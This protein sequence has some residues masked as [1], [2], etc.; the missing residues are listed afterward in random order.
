MEGEILLIN[1]G[2]TI[3]EKGLIL[4][5]LE[6][7]M[8]E[9]QLEYQREKLLSLGFEIKEP[10]VYSYQISRGLLCI[11]TKLIEDGFKPTYL[12]MDYEKDQHPEES[13]EKIL[14]PH[15]QNAKIA[16][17][18]SYTFNFDDAVE[19]AKTL[20]LTNPE[21]KVIFGGPHVTWLDIETIENPYID[22]VVRG[23]GENIFRDVCRNLLNG[24]NLS[25]IKG[26]TYKKENGEIVRNSP[27]PFLKGEEIPMPAYAL[28]KSIKNPT[29]VI[30][31]TRG[32]PMR[33]TFCAE[34]AFWKIV[35]HRKINDV[36][37]ELKILRSV[38]GY[39]A[40]H[41]C[42]PYFPINKKYSEEL[43]HQI[44][45]EKI[46]MYFNCNVRVDKLDMDT[47]RLLS[48]SNFYGVF[49]GIESGS[50]RVLREMRKGITYEEY[51]SCLK[52]IRKYIPII[53]T[54]W[55]VGH[56]GENVDTI[57]ESKEKIKLLLKE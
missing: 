20:K 46:E 28:I 19:I 49:I 22:I 24:K 3:L 4:E 34:S 51:Y 48:S 52:K 43:L 7:R 54:S 38:L 5:P 57:K 2:S 44:K 1:P 40:I 8:T 18:T 50:N 9:I 30:E 16:R 29:I 14:R 42:D 11:A 53:D 41:I 25:E 45:T 17:I 10:P 13:I 55:M 36:V 23:E 47:L 39:N 37:E 35:R 26:I 6:K 15:T 56:P 33:C 31:T 12:Q 21:I 32:C 27:A